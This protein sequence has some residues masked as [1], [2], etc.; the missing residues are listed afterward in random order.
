MVGADIAIRLH[1]RQG[2]MPSESHFYALSR[3]EQNERAK[4]CQEL[5]NGSRI[6]QDSIGIA[7]DERTLNPC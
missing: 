6:L 5:C 3:E 4:R 1:T 7:S 2:E